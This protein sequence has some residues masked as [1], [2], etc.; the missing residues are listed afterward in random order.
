MLKSNGGICQVHLRILPSTEMLLVWPDLAPN[1][2]T[3]RSA[4]ARGERG[5]EVWQEKQGFAA[6]CAAW[7]ESIGNPSPIYN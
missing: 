6:A 3:Y 2:L 7:R 1:D 4:L 5:V